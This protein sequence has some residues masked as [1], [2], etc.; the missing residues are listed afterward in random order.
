MS[1]SAKKFLS[2]TAFLLLAQNAFSAESKVYTTGN[3]NFNDLGY[4]GS[5]QS[6]QTDFTIKLVINTFEAR[7]RPVWNP[8]S[9][10][11]SLGFSVGISGVHFLV[12]FPTWIAGPVDGTK[13]NDAML[14]D[15][16]LPPRI[17]SN[18]TI[19]SAFAA[20]NLVIIKAAAQPSL[21]VADALGAYNSA[22]RTSHINYIRFR[23]DQSGGAACPPAPAVAPGWCTNHANNESQWN[24]DYSPVKQKVGLQAARFLTRPL[25]LLYAGL[26]SAGLPNADTR[27]RTPD[28]DNT[29]LNW[30][31]PSPNQ[32]EAQYTAE[33][34]NVGSM[35]KIYWSA[36]LKQLEIRASIPASTQGWTYY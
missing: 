13:P 25:A 28:F 24:N 32:S 26:A 7:Q 17:Y 29:T 8:I 20:R 30:G 6:G 11:G 5:A 15:L 27:W 3:E 34:G 4:S 19:T 16:T 2:V 14:V 31:N 10:T 22:D 18:G 12:S 36:D 9:P 21:I 1:L 23:F 33:D 35:I